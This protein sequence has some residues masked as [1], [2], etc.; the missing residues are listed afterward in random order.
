M[1]ASLGERERE[2]VILRFFGGKSFAEIGTQLD[3]SESGARMRVD[4]ALE[5]LRLRLSRRGVAS[6][7][8]ALGAILAENGVMAAPATLAPAA[9]ATAVSAPAAAGFSVAL[10]TLQI[11][12]TTKITLGVA[13][14]VTL[15]SLAAAVHEYRH[16]QAAD[17]ALAGALRTE[18]T[19]R[20]AALPKAAGASAPASAPASSP[21]ATGTAPGGAP[22]NPM[23]S[24]I[25]LLGN[26]AI[27]QQNQ[28]LARSRLDSQYGA[29]FKSLAL[30][31]DQIAQFKNLLVEK[32]MVGFDSM[33]AAK[34]QGIDPVSDPRGFF[35]AVA[36]AEKTVDG[37]IAV[38]LGSDG[39][40][41]F[42]QY[43]QT[44]PARN[45]SLQL[46][47]ALSYTAAPLTEAQTASVIQV[48]TQYGTP[49][50]PPANPFAVLNGDLGV[51]QLSEAGLTQ[52]QA[53]LSTPQLQA[54]QEKM[55]QQAQ[56]L[57]ARKQ[58]RP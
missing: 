17:L 42:Q 5:K 35:Q 31:P 49:A 14:A 57:A 55:E 45:T 8:A 22:R 39:F 29:L 47:Q 38:L 33:A 6:S 1:V 48:L 53:I 51:V 26:P 46:G 58:I 2:A 24:L 20:R 43:Q 27:Q 40:S 9:I 21:G 54:L 4:R 18:E 13:A 37:Q 34:E 28:I 11:M 36:G 12:T 50:L 10:V 30:A 16:A 44:V 23:V 3:L 32:E 25:D 15:L 7:A 52:L 19:A 56:I 41:Q